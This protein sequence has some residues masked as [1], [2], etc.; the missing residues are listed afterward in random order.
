MGRCSFICSV[1]ARLTQPFPGHLNAVRWVGRA[2]PR[3]FHRWGS[4]GLEGGST[5]FPTLFAADIAPSLSQGFPSTPWTLQKAGQVTWGGSER[6]ACGPGFSLEETDVCVGL[7]GPPTWPC[8]HDHP[9]RATAQ[10]RSACIPSAE[11]TAL[12]RGVPS[13]GP[14]GAHRASSDGTWPLE[15]PRSPRDKA[16]LATELDLAA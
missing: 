9:H 4:R 6:G 15:Q 8:E 1:G 11:S 3:P 16:T 5:A 13:G 12:G 10:G 2:G 14:L 7:R